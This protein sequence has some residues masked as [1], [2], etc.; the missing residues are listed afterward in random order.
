MKLTELPPF[1]PRAA[2]FA[3]AAWQ[4]PS[5]AIVLG[6]DNLGI[7]EAVDALVRDHIAAPFALQP[8]GD[9]LGRPP[10]CEPFNDGVSQA[11]IAFESGSL[12]ASR[13]TPLVGVARFVA[14][15]SPIALQFPRD[16]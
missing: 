1:L 9:L 7:D 12:P 6:A 16:R 10:A 5:P 11:L 15:L 2:S 13:P 3:F 8:A 14:R 4:A